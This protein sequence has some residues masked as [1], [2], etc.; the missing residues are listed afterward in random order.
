M[1]ENYTKPNCVG[2]AEKLKYVPQQKH[3]KVKSVNWQVDRIAE[4][5]KNS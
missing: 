1:W 3:I 4:E 2:L 5:N